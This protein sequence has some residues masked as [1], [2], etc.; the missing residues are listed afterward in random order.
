MRNFSLRLTWQHRIMPIVRIVV[1]SLMISSILLLTGQAAGEEDAT[2]VHPAH[3]PPAEPMLPPSTGSL[4]GAETVSLQ[5]GLSL[6]VNSTG[7]N[8]DKT[9]GNGICADRTGACTL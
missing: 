9:A 1:F 3:Q 4:Q 6:I 2:L 8:G 7:D 5:T